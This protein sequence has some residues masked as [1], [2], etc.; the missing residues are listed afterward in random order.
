MNDLDLTTI[1]SIVAGILYLLIVGVIV[2]R[3]RFREWSVRL[4]LVYTVVLFILELVRAA[5]GFGWPAFLTDALAAQVMAYGVLV[6]AV[7]FLS[8]SRFFLRLKGT[9]W[10]W[11]VLGAAWVAL[12]VALNN[13]LLPLP[14][15]LRTNERWLI[16][17][18]GPAFSALLL[19]WT[20]F[21]LGA[22]FSTVIVYSRMSQPLHR[23]RIVYWFLTTTFTITGGVLFFVVALDARYEPLSIALYLLGTLS[24]A[25]AVMT[26]HLFDM[27]QA[28]RQ[29]VNYLI[30]TLLA[31]ALYTGAFLAADYAFR[32]L[33]GYSP[34][35]TGVALAL[36][37]AI[38]F[39]PLLRLAQRLVGRLLSG[40]GYNPTR[41]LREYSASISNILDLEQLATVS[42]GLISEAMEIRQ[43]AL[44][45]VHHEGGEENGRFYLRGVRGIGEGADL[46]PSVLSGDSPV[47]DYWRREHAPLSQYDI[48]LHPRF[49]ETAPQERDWL[50][51]LGMDVY[52]PIYA[53]EEWIGLLA[54][55]PK[56]S[57]NRYFEDELGLLS[58]LA[59]QTAVA[60]ENA[61]LFEDLK[62]R[63][64]EIGRLN[65]D[66]AQANVELARM[67]QAKSDFIDIA[68]H[69]LRTPLTQVRGYT[70]ILKE[71]LEGE[72]LVPE[73]GGKLIAGLKL[74]AERLEEIINTMFDVAQIDTATLELN[75]FPESI[76]SIVK[77]AAETWH[78]A[79]QERK[80]TLTIE[81][82][83]NLP[84]IAADHK[85]LKQ[86]FSHLIQNAIKFTPDGGQIRITGQ[87]LAWTLPQD[88]AV[89]IVVA[90]TG[91]GI[92]SEE[93]ERIFEKFYRVGDVL[94]H[95]TGKSKFKGAGPGLGLTIARGI[96]EAHGGRI[97]AE[98]PGCD[99]QTCPGGE[100]HVVLPVQ[101]RSSQGDR[102]V[103]ATVTRRGGS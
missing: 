28:V 58:T 50:A 54:L 18:Q 44:F 62:A 45:V 6:L 73:S 96:V 87:M 38:L 27:R 24:A 95:S 85:R 90:D 91:I 93:L 63:N 20:I 68:S 11:W 40:A 75:L 16:A 77:A 2:Q 60:L 52:V 94:L 80:Q 86:A 4:L 32:T 34:L 19:G 97:W 71:M 84:S 55:G 1:A 101:P 64:V 56:L 30:G 98:S 76:A 82:L 100:F 15:V 39:D 99:E 23:N 22:L 83:D 69:E 8:L 47:A 29:V 81:G 103:F 10:G 89:E 43:G 21:V 72:S 79:L 12:L 42:M 46:A 48:D 59:D 33:P 7:L 102:V 3:R 37:L 57:G 17:G 13:E 9:G 88:Q 51:G 67:G 92:A 41:T 5:S 49:Q 74:A 26:H 65:E 61:R 66:L 70:D 78:E 36:A 35:L 53:K 25:Y 14:E 31:A